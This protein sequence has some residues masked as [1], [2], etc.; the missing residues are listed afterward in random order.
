MTL[1]KFDKIYLLLIFV[2]ALAA[3][4]IISDLGDSRFE[5]VK[6][7]TAFAPN[8]DIADELGEKVEGAYLSLE[9]ININEADSY[10]LQRLSGIGEATAEKIIDFRIKNGNFA[11][12]Q[13]IMKVDGIGRKTFEDI[14]DYITIE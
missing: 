6:N 2:F 8:D 11:V 9:K 4:A 1:Q 5:I 12:I 3:G 10:D 13:D 7:S 14:K